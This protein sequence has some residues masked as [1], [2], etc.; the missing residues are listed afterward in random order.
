MRRRQLSA[1]SEWPL[2]FLI[3]RQDT[4]PVSTEISDLLVEVPGGTVFARR[5]SSTSTSARSDV[6]S[7]PFTATQMSMDP[8]NFPA[9]LRV[10]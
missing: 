1:A 4:F 6:L 9:A 2:K 3:K 10:G 7:W 8:W 5:W